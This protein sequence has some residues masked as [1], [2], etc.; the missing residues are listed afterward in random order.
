MKQIFQILLALILAVTAAADSSVPTQ[1][2]LAAADTS[3][4]E[5]MRLHFSSISAIKT[6]IVAGQL[7]GV[8]ESALWL[9][10]HET[11]PGLPGDWAPYVEQ[12]RQYADQ[13]ASA[14]HL[15]F[16]AAAVSEMARI[17]GDCHVA[18]G[19]DLVLAEI[20][21]PP[22]G[23]GVGPQ[24]R[25]QHWAVDRMWE[26]LIV[27]SDAAWNQGTR[28]LAK[29]R[30]T[31]ADFNIAADKRPTASYLIKR[32]RELGEAGIQAESPEA[33]SA[34]YGELLSLCGDCHILTGG[35]PARR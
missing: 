1:H 22:G 9:K 10:E 8:S 11:S 6:F 2:E 28:T 13:T 34:I 29:V 3:V 20:T 14:K 35:G 30:L 16:A 24:M 32:T 33:R 26:G 15:V 31:A 4:A 12:M 19:V 21:P 18:N 23:D 25:Q 17:C 5:H 7:E 27:P